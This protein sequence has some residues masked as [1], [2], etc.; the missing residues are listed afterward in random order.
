MMYN[1][2]LYH[3]FSFRFATDLPLT[4]GQKRGLANAV[5][6]VGRI[7]EIDLQGVCSRGAALSGVN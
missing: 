5:K 4:R 6:K 2:H 7:L 1:R 3:G